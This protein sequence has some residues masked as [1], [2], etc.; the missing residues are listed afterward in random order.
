M[1]KYI[2]SLAALYENLNSNFHDPCRTVFLLL[3]GNRG[4]RKVIPQKCAK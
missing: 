4:R 2:K 1:A 3:P